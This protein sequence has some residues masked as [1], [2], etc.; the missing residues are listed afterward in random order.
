MGIRIIGRFK[1]TGL[2]KAFIVNDLFA[3]RP[4]FDGNAWY[5]NWGSGD[6][7]DLVNE[8]INLRINQ[9][10]VQFTEVEQTGN[11]WYDIWSVTSAENRFITMDTIASSEEAVAIVETPWYN[12]WGSAGTYIVSENTI[13]IRIQTSAILETTE[14]FVGTIDE[15]N[16]RAQDNKYITSANAIELRVN[17]SASMTQIT[18][19]APLDISAYNWAPHRDH[20]I[21]SAAAIELRVNSSAEMV[22]VS[23]V[24]A[25]FIDAYNWA[26][27]RDHQITSANAIELRVN[28]SAATVQSRVEATAITW[29]T[30]WSENGVL[31]RD[32]IAISSQ[33]SAVVNPLDPLTTA[34]SWF[35]N[36]GIND[37]WFLATNNIVFD[38]TGDG[39]VVGEGLQP[40]GWYDDWGIT[41]SWTLGA[42]SLVFDMT[43]DGVILGDGIAAPNDWYEAWLSGGNWI[44]EDNNLAFDMADTAEVGNLLIDGSPPSNWE[45]NWNGDVSAETAIVTSSLSNLRVDASSPS[46]VWLPGFSNGFG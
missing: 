21:T 37:G 43:S 44:L 28:S 27:Y 31:A 39:V 45:N 6:S 26:P 9:S 5:V 33:T 35:D 14:D 34:A 8:T 1:P 11:K 16:W 10:A 7:F 18:G 17:S 2:I 46:T 4:P 23:G 20:Q 13:G 15:Y 30:D 41:D 3:P 42:N 29:F 19:I 36:W 24:S 38:M 22:K 12:T 40:N 25:K 32:I